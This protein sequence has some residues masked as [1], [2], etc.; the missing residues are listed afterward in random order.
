[1]QSLARLSSRTLP[2][3]RPTVGVHRADP[4]PPSS[5]LRL[6]PMLDT[7]DFIGVIE[8]ARLRTRRKA[9]TTNG[10]CISSEDAAR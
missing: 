5:G 10:I 9:R 7:G 3:L 4:S 6:P 2:V 8:A 1:M